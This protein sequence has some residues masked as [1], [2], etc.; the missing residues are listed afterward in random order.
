MDEYREILQEHFEGKFETLTI[1]K[2]TVIDKQYLEM[3]ENL[4]E[5]A[6]VRTGTARAVNWKFVM[7]M[8][9]PERELEERE[10]LNEMFWEKWE[11]F[12]AMRP[13]PWDNF[14]IRIALKVLK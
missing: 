9:D 14:M 8:F 11:E 4:K 10:R 12:T 1:E 7:A 5:L 2:V 6:K 13:I 3:R